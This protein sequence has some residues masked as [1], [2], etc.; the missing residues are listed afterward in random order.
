MDDGDDL[1]ENTKGTFNSQNSIYIFSTICIT[2]CKVLVQC[3]Y[4]RT[5]EKGHQRIPQSWNM[6]AVYLRDLNYWGLAPSLVLLVCG[7]QDPR[8]TS[9]STH[10]QIR[11]LLV[12]LVFCMLGVGES[13]WYDISSSKLL[14][15]VHSYREHILPHS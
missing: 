14:G 8:H 11:E 4:V 3:T 12:L 2:V 9:N 10:E 6:E 1:L 13:G 15:L 7:I 5:Y